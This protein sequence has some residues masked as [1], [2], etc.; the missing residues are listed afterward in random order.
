MSFKLKE[1]QESMRKA[2]QAFANGMDIN[3]AM[4]LYN[5]S[6]ASIYNAIK[7]YNIKYEYTYGRS[8]FF[9]IDY[10]QDIDCEHKAYWLG[11]IFADGTVIKSDDNVSAPNRMRLCI[12][13][14][15]EC[16][17]EKFAEDIRMSKEYIHHYV[18]HHVNNYS[19][20]MVSV[21]DCNSIKMASDLEKLGC[22]RNKTYNS[23]VP[24]FS[25]ELAKH[26]IRGYFDGDG[27]IGHTFNITSELHA[28]Q[29]MQQMLMRD[30]GFRQTK[31]IPDKGA[32][33]MS[34]GGKNQ[35]QKLFYYL[36]DSATVF[37]QRK[38]DKFYSVAFATS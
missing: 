15:D 22:C 14:R 12:S 27:N 31:I 9:D 25:P 1:K 28:L 26:F 38:Y 8:N 29:Q 37:L 18:P 30:L 36:Y 21:I 33:R 6:Y 20:N 11:F 2:A 5:V 17:L 35:L 13:A 23:S 4:T 24:D 7:R 34:Y 19:H 32:W 3:E 16:L 10:F